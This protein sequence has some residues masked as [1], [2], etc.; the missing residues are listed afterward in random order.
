MGPLMYHDSNN[1]RLTIAQRFI[2]VSTD[3]VYG[4]SSAVGSGKRIACDQPTRMRPAR[5]RPKC[6]SMRIIFHSRCRW[7]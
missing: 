7:W 5:L 4:E 1:H 6:S 3:E 2:Y